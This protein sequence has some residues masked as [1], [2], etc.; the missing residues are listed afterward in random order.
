MISSLKL[1]YKIT[2]Q[3]VNP[4]WLTARMGEVEHWERQ[5]SGEAEGEVKLLEVGELWAEGMEKGHG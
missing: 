1:P 3:T 4:V 2:T 5:K